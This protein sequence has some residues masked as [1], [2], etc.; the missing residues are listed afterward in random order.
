[1]LVFNHEEKLEVT[2]FE[3]SLEKIINLNKICPKQKI[4]GTQPV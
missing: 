2:I 1:M 3:N 4:A